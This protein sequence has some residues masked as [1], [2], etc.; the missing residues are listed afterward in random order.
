MNRNTFL[1]WDDRRDSGIPWFDI[2]EKDAIFDML[3]Q[4]L[5]FR[6]E[7]CP[8]TK[9]IFESEWMVIWALPENGKISDNV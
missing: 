6:P 2:N 9:E 5:S 8:T 3:R 7:N 1:S 4:M